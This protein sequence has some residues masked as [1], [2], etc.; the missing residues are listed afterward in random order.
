MK[1]PS[2]IGRLKSSFTTR[3]ISSP[4]ATNTSDPIVASRAR[5][6]NS[7]LDEQADFEATLATIKLPD[8]NVSRTYPTTL[9]E[10]FSYD[11]QPTH[12]SSFRTILIVHQ[13][14]NFFDSWTITG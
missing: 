2:Y 8:G 1:T 14:K 6:E 3:E 11:G 9:K 10:L 5:H 13:N 12:Q 4:P 7:T